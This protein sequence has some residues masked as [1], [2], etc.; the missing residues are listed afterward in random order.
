MWNVKVVCEILL[1]SLYIFKVSRGRK[2]NFSSKRFLSGA[3]QIPL[4]SIQLFRERLS[5]KVHATNPNGI[6]GGFEGTFLQRNLKEWYGRPRTY[7]CESKESNNSRFD[8]FSRYEQCIDH[9]PY[10][11]SGLSRA[12]FFRQPFLKQLYTHRDRGTV[13]KVIHGT[14]LFHHTWISD[15][16]E[17]I[18]IQKLEKDK[19]ISPKWFFQY[20]S[21]MPG[22]ANSG[23]RNYQ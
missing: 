23:R 18:Y 4:I 11:I 10:Y 6:V 13:K 3:R 15:V 17:N 9:I 1:K 5:V 8:S 7:V 12:H 22:F 21:N 2:W 16:G 20:D 19:Q 14:C